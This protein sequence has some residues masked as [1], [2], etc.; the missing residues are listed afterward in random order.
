MALGL[1]SNEVTG[2]RLI[3]RFVQFAEF[4]IPFVLFFVIAFIIIKDLLHHWS[5]DPQQ[6][7]Q[8]DSCW[9]SFLI[10]FKSGKDT[11]VILSEPVNLTE[12]SSIS[13]VVGEVS[14][15]FSCYVEATKPY[16]ASLP[17]KKAKSTSVLHVNPFLASVS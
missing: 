7:C 6:P 1:C 11:H 5:L 13:S 14:L 10:G 17:L 3:T 4:Q 9:C 16:S 2:I 8:I 12:G 15:D